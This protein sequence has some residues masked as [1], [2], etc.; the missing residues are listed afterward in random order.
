MAKW[1]WCTKCK[2]MTIAAGHL[3]E[4]IEAGYRH[5]DRTFDCYLC[6]TE[7]ERTNSYFTIPRPQTKTAGG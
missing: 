1:M 2:K 7:L 3:H 6:G 4:H 5:F